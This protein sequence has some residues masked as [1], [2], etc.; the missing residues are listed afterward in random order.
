MGT[1]DVYMSYILK[2]QLAIV[3]L[4]LV[5]IKILKL[6]NHITDMVDDVKI[7]EKTL[8]LKNHIIV[9]VDDAKV[10]F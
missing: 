4:A 8:K 3:S 10:Y 5:Q 1:E 7:L 6:K 2:K 9:M